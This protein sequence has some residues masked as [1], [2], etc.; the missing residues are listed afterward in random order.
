MLG[1]FGCS[2]IVDSNPARISSSPTS[3]I[4]STPSGGGG[5]DPLA[6]E[7]A[8]KD[9]A[10]SPRARLEWIWSKWGFVQRSSSINSS[11]VSGGRV[12]APSVRHLQTHNRLVSNSM[13]PL[14]WESCS[15]SVAGN[16][17]FLSD[18]SIITLERRISPWC[19]TSKRVI[20]CKLSLYKCFF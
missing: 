17:F 19:T 15:C 11:R 16:L 4:G 3:L 10:G 6:P 1:L 7:F 14:D 18:K 13:W 5:S 9:A 2:T 20:L 12:Y 8:H